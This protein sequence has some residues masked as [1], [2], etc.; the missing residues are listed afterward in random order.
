MLKL[1]IS[2]GVFVVYIDTRSQVPNIPSKSCGLADENKI[3]FDGMEMI[4][5]KRIQ[6]QY[7]TISLYLK[8]GLIRGVASL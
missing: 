5:N 8:C 2:I 6:V 7:F 1:H 4:R 3:L